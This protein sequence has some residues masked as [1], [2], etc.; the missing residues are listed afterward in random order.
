MPATP[1]FTASPSRPRT[2]YPVPANETI[3][4]L[5][6]IFKNATGYGE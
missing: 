6:M 3:L 1:T 5:G 2:Y 4:R